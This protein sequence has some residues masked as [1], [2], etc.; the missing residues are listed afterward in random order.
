M[1]KMKDAMQNQKLKS[2]IG[3]DN[4]TGSRIVAR[5]SENAAVTTSRADVQYVATEYGCVNLKILSM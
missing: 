3:F 2:P 5:L 4:K 1:H